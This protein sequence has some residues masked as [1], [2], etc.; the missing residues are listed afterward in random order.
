[1]TGIRMLVMA[2]RTPD[3]EKLA[4]KDLLILPGI[5]FR[6]E[7]GGSELVHFIGLFSNTDDIDYIWKQIQVKCKID[8]ADIL[9]RGGYERV[10]CDFKETAIRNCW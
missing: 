2:E 7:L 1:V 3:L 6:S 9:K 10:I 8:D 4:G 5:E